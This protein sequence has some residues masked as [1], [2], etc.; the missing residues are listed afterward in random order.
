[1]DFKI[2]ILENFWS[3]IKNNN[4]E[5]ISLNIIY[6]LVTLFIIYAI[7]INNIT[8][9][10][11]FDINIITF[12]QQKLSNIPLF[13]PT[14]ADS[15]LYSIF[16]AVP[17]ISNL[18]FFFR[19]YL[20]I[21]IV[22][23]SSSPLVAYIF[24]IIIKNIVQRPRPPI[25]MQ[26]VIQ[27]STYSFV[28]SH[29]LITTTL[30]G[31]TIYYLNKYCRNKI[32]KY[33]GIILGIFWMMFVGISRIWLGVHNPTDIIGGYFLGLILVYI[34]IKLIKLIGGKC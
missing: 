1:M 12:L 17:I 5:F 20:L 29:T 7:L 3:I 21:D 19:K 24:N 11:Q 33:S 2:I 25:E 6:C 27:P 18:I 14:L 8:A 10:T 9:V 16:I 26:L 15:I 28:S 22:L 30:W 13:I 23:Y 4:G 32:L 34:Y 31:L